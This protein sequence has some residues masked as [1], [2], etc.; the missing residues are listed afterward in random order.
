MFSILGSDLFVIWQNVC[1]NQC[2]S[3]SVMYRILYGNFSSPPS[4]HSSS[5]IVITGCTTPGTILKIKAVLV[6]VGKKRPLTK[7]RVDRGSLEIT[8]VNLSR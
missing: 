1:V 4:R 7:T 8:T 6:K 2:T 5:S 3:R